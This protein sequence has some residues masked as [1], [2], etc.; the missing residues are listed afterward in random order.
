MDEFARSV[1]K[2]CDY[3]GSRVIWIGFEEVKRRVSANE[4]LE[5]V[6]L[7]LAYGPMS[8]GWICSDCDNFGVFGLSSAGR[9][10]SRRAG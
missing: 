3:C 8:D 10:S 1:R 4:R 7:E 5:L 9:S 2:V 6:V